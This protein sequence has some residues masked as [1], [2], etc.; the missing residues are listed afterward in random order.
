MLNFTPFWNKSTW[1]Y[2]ILEWTS[3]SIPVWSKKYKIYSK[4]SLCVWSKFIVQ[5]F[6]LCFMDFSSH[7]Y[8]VLTSECSEKWNRAIWTWTTE[9]MTK[10]AI[11]LQQSLIN[12][13]WY[14]RE[15]FHLFDTFT[16]IFMKSKCEKEREREQAME[17][18]ETR[19]NV[20]IFLWMKNPQQIL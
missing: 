2:T 5:N 14:E 6:P 12:F 11:Q 4:I 10:S 17:K 16:S 1:N 20:L 13:V 8:F 15:S 9:W 7:S 18:R 19:P 3:F